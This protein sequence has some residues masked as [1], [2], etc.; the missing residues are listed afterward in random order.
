MTKKLKQLWNELKQALKTRHQLVSENKTLNLKNQNL[1]AQ[2]MQLR[3][4][5]TSE[6]GKMGFMVSAFIPME[7]LA[8]LRDRPVLKQDF[9][10]QVAGA[11][12][13]SAIDGLLHT[14]RQGQVTALVFEPPTWGPSHSPV[15][16][17]FETDKGS[18]VYA[19]KS[20]EDAHKDKQHKRKQ[21]CQSHS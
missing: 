21:L 7:T 5:N 18:Y 10:D 13:N 19:R 6:P 9:K 20:V 15:S 1:R 14:T 11:L 16:A 8:S 4:W 2:M 17:I 12:V 3:V